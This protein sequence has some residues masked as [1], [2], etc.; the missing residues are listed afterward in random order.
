MRILHIAGMS[1]SGKT[2]LIEALIPMLP[3][4]EVLK[5]THHTLPADP[6][7]SDTGRFQSL[8]TRTLLAGPEGIWG[9]MAVPR[10]QVYAWLAQSLGDDDLLIVEGDKGSVFPKIWMG[11]GDIPQESICLV[12][13]PSPPPLNGPPWIASSMP[14][15]EDE[16]RAIALYLSQHWQEYTYRISG[17]QYP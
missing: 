6:I 15:E 10:E 4:H 3:V 7:E 17:G 13:S 11:A 1:N 14:P 2:R 12:V 16:I 9:H 8:G 5:W